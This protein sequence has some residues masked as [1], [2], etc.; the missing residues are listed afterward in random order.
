M[1]LSPGSQHRAGRPGWRE[2]LARF[3]FGDLIGELAS[4]SVRVDD[5]PGWDDLTA[6]WPADRPWAD[7]YVDLTDALEA[8][9]KN[10]FVRRLVTLTRSYVVGP[11][12]AV[13][14]KHRRVDAFAQQFWDH[15][16][17]RMA[18]RLGP[19]CDELTRAGEVFPTLFTNKVDG[20]SY[21]RFVPA[22][23][24]SGIETEKKDYE[25]ELRYA[26]KQR[27]TVKPKWWV[28]PDNPAA[29][30]VG[31]DGG[32]PPVMLHFCVN[33]VIGATRGEGDLGPILPWARR[34]SEW[35]KDR[36]K[37]NRRRTRQ[38]MMDVEIADDNLVEEKVAKLQTRNPLEHGVYVHGKGE[39]VTVHGLK[40]EADDAEKDGQ[41]LRLAVA[42]GANV[43]LHYVGEGTTVN[44]ATAKEM[45][46]P[47]SRFFS[48]R[49]QEV[50]WMVCDLTEVAHKRKVAMGLA[51]P[52]R[53]GYQ[54][55]VSSA[56]VARA[57]NQAL[58]AA[59]KDIVESLLGMAA[60]GWIDD[61]TAVKMAFK[62]AG[63]PL[64]EDEVQRILEAEPNTEP[65]T[66]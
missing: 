44:Y 9:R 64:G 28:G 56:E 11:G 20:M 24:I 7:R 27:D 21:V 65:D 31:D 48:D 42:T 36:V 29:F 3:L 41:V 47:T 33:R 22:S 49:Q 60:K 32:L 50:G 16:K 57:D 46:E 2:R 10:F 18:R 12:M 43:A 34:Y 63:E 37:L 6:R 59:A 61:E 66:D 5:S 52:P 30:K 17:N 1:A 40:I 35:L 8:W 54:W 26:E 53:G 13:S 38:A 4:V 19:M 23:E 15:P 14:S 25:I 62:F 55:Q 45:G 58:A 51:G 39:V